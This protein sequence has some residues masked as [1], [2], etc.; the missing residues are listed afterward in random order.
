MKSVLFSLFISISFLAHAQ[1]SLI[2][3][4][5][6]D[7]LHHYNDQYVGTILPRQMLDQKHENFGGFP[8]RYNI[9]YPNHTAEV[10]E[11]LAAAYVSDRSS[12]FLQDSVLRRLR[13][14]IT[15][16]LNQQHPDGTID[17]LST[18]FHS[19]PDLAFAVEP[20]ARSFKI[21]TRQ[22]RSET[23]AVRD[24]MQTFLKQGGEALVRGG[25][26]TP[27][28]RW[29]VSMALAR[30]YDLFGDERYVQ[31]IDQWLAEGIDI[32]PEGQYTERSTG[33][34]S[35]LTNRCFI[36]I[37]RLLGRPALLDPVRKNLDMSIYYL[38]PNGEVVTEAS[39][40]QDQYRPRLPVPYYY[41]YR[42]M[43]LEDE[44]DTYG[45][46]AF[47]LQNQLG[48]RVLSGTLSHF[49]EEESLWEKMP[50]GKVPVKYERHFP[51]SEL[52]RFRD[53]DWDATLLAKNSTLLTMHHGNTILQG[54]RISS[55]F[56]GK[57]QMIADT[58]IVL[59]SSYTLSQELKGPYYQP[60]HRDSISG[61][62]I[63]ENMPRENREQSEVQSI[64]YK[65]KVIPHG[66]DSMV[67]KIQITGTD[68]VPV[69][70][71][72]S[73]RENGIFKNTRPDN[74]D[75]DIHFLAEGYGSFGDEES[76]IYFGP[77]LHE[78][79][80]TV[81]RGAEEKIAGKSVYLTGYTP[82]NHTLYL[83]PQ[84]H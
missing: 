38:H 5:W 55:A 47:Q 63:W 20:I 68:H 36:T 54:L 39:R 71:E 32:D 74:A 61:D 11:R 50:L 2:D 76:R 64:R 60:F 37:S 14:A 30:L 67:V 18:N 83:S 81:L 4:A 44:N 57:G 26:H 1:N 46:I 13:Y 33:I 48:P 77:G 58:L 35:P 78:H 28:H 34:Y 73:F 80:W 23:E 41:S 56:F 59:D 24:L 17:L 29:V 40:R 16:M 15:F 25:I 69:A 21:L 70:V 84:Q 27:N 19:T 3:D 72:L 10:I 45:A 42:Y 52:V 51:E 9:Y 7:S 62:G 22:G 82:F 66:L 79:T 75:T 6:I 8:D 49:L 43:A 31:R 65:V 12:L 53:G